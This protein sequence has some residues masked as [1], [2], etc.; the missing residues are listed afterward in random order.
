MKNYEYYN[1]LNEKM[2]QAK[3]NNNDITDLINSLNCMNSY[4]DLFVI[5][6]SNLR[7]MGVSEAVYKKVEQMTIDEFN[8]QRTEDEHECFFGVSSEAREI[9]TFDE[10]MLTCGRKDGVHFYEDALK[11][12]INQFK[13]RNDSGNVIDHFLNYVVAHNYDEIQ[14]G[15]WDD[16]NFTADCYECTLYGYPLGR[17]ILEK[18]EME[19]GEEFFSP[20]SLHIRKNLQGLRLGAF[21]L[22]KMMTDM[23][24]K[25]PN[26][27]LVLPTVLRSNVNALKLYN[28]LGATVYVDGELVEDPINGMDHSVSEN[29]L[30]VF[31]PSAIKK[32]ANTVINKPTEKLSHINNFAEGIEH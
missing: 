16:A 12:V 3:I 25:H 15:I 5:F 23:N 27:P 1:L 4:K 28:S 32:Y 9:C 14:Y 8:V 11:Y 10:M 17:M 7:K 29:C 19:D 30:V 26:E 21:L 22:Q 2:N 13:T 31:E 18:I 6:L 24:K 20:E